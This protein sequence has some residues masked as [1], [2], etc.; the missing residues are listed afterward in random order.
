[1][2]ASAS[3]NAAYAMDAAGAVATPLIVPAGGQFVTNQ[4]VTITGAVGATL[5][6]TVNG[7]DP[8]ASDSTI[9]SGGTVV[10][11]KSQVLKVRAFQGGLTDSVVRRADFVITGSLIAGWQ[12]VHALKSDGTVWSWGSSGLGRLGDGLGNVTRSTPY[13]ILTNVR[14]ISTKLDHS[15]ALKNDGTVWTWGSSNYGKLG[16]SVF[17]STPTPTQVAGLTNIAAVAAGRDH[18]LVLKADG[19]VWAFGNNGSGQLGNGSAVANSMTPVQV[20][21]LTNVTAIVAGEDFSL[22]L[23]SDGADRGLVWAWGKND[24]GQLGDGTL[25]DKFVPIRVANLTDVKAMAAGSK[26][27]A[28]LLA[29]G[30]IWTWGDN[31][32]GQLGAGHDI[33]KSLPVRAAPIADGRTISAGPFTASSIGADAVYWAW[34]RAQQGEAG[35]PS[36][37]MA[38]VAWVP[39][40]VTSFPA[41]MAVA[42]MDAAALAVKANGS[43]WGIGANGIGQL[44]NG[45]TSPSTTTVWGAVTSSFSLTD[46]AWLAGDQDSDGLSAWQ[47]YLRGLD[48]LNPDTNGNGIVDGAE[49]SGS[50]GSHPDSDGD[51]VSNIREVQRGTDPFSVDTDGDGTNDGTDAFPLDPTRSTAPPPVPGDVTP[52]TITLTEP[53][54]AIPVPF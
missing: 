47:E 11:N 50:G 37:H 24:Q 10:V 7:A 2:T 32:W 13:Q 12:H 53:T 34:G 45:G 39:Q 26:F 43:V 38:D 8:T 49:P 52:P 18:T 29:N 27:A 36:V 30:E 48:P 41:P 25:V 21:G 44:G 9:A 19:T 4:T 3:A 6:Y 15:I 20:S 46:N 23:T 17:S 1:M 40:R 42:P 14:A 22:A 33:D 28:A 54:N 31:A 35:G 16:F 51:G 5:R